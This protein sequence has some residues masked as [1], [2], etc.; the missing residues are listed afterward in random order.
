MSAH[1]MEKNDACTDNE[2]HAMPW[3]RDLM[4]AEESAAW[5]ATR[6]AAGRAIDIATCELG[7][8]AA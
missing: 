5:V 6:E 4:T 1:E 2:L 7:R 3:T 8:W